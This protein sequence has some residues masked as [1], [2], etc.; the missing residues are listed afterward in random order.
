MLSLGTKSEYGISVPSVNT[1][2]LY[3]TVQDGKIFDVL[4]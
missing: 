3:L 2:P 1:L 4:S